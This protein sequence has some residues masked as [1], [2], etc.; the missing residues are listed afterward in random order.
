MK[1]FVVV[2]FCIL[3]M[4][5]LV[6]AERVFVKYKEDKAGLVGLNANFQINNSKI[7][8]SFSNGNMQNI[9]SM[10]TFIFLTLFSFHAQTCG[11]I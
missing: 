2:L 5:S 7:K 11:A 4:L 10:H 8:Y 9:L 1:K 6:S 3:F